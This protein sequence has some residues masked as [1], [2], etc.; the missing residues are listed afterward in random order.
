MI[1]PT[2]TATPPKSTYSLLYLYT[3]FLF[4]WLQSSA[5]I[6]VHLPI[7]IQLPIVSYACL[8]FK[9]QSIIPTFQFFTT[10]MPSY[11][12]YHISLVSCVH[13]YLVCYTY[14]YLPIW[15]ATKSQ[16][17]IASL[18]S[19]LQD[20]LTESATMATNYS[21]LYLLFSFL[22]HVCLATQITISPQ[23]PVCMSTQFAIPIPTY[24]Y[25]QLLSPSQVQPVYLAIYRI[26]LLSLLLWLPSLFLLTYIQSS[27]YNYLPVVCWSLPIAYQQV[28][29]PYHA[30]ACIHALTALYLY[31]D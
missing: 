30:G 2:Q 7:A 31:L 6:E 19:Y 3:Q 15:L 25:G 1:L 29:L 4:A 20:M 26:C 23:S 13:V 9:L 8:L 17:G 21:L 10:C 27:L 5:P 24:L 16:L 22:L 12:D 14:T 18:S 28:Y 11:L